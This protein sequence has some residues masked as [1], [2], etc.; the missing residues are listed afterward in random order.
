MQFLEKGKYLNQSVDERDTFIN[1]SSF[2]IHKIRAEVQTSI[3]SGVTYVMQ[4][5]DLSQQLNRKPKHHDCKLL[6]L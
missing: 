2:A 6:S 4:K 3:S 1:V 5:C